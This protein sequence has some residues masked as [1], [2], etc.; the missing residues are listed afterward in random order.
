MFSDLI[1]SSLESTDTPFLIQVI[2]LMSTCLSNIEVQS[3]WVSSIKSK[4]SQFFSTIQYTLENNLNSDL[5]KALFAFINKILYIDDSL[6]SEWLQTDQQ[7]QCIK[8]LLQ[9]S[10]QLITDSIENIEYI[11]Y[12]WLILHS[13]S[14]QSQ[15]FFST[16][17][18]YSQNE[19]IPL[20]ES[21]ITTSFGDSVDYLIS[22]AHRAG[23]LSASISLCNQII[24]SSISS[25]ETT[26]ANNGQLID[27]FH[28]LLINCDQSILQMS[29][30]TEA[31]QLASDQLKA[32]I[33]LFSYIK[34]KSII[35]SEISKSR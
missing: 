28:H 24:S 34:S 25:Y 19:V 20:F 17:I 9:A 14:L 1:L 32:I 29:S 4:S 21:Y 16:H 31:F 15:Q 7:N 3:L 30:N 12:L 23:A 13:L 27:C 18:Y 8:C 26:V 6:A 11:D 33:E 22:S 35:K 10:N 2:R 5:L